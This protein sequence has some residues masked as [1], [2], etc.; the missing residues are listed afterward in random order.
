[1]QWDR[2]RGGEGRRRGRIGRCTRHRG[3]RRGSEGAVAQGALHRLPRVLVGDGQPG[4]MKIAEDK[5]LLLQHS[6][7]RRTVYDRLLSALIATVVSGVGRPAE[8]KRS[9][10]SEPS[11]RK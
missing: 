11:S 9:F 4:R 10:A 2:R 7:I 5:I 8:D 1:M 6:E 3:Q